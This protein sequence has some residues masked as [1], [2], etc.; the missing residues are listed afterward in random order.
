MYQLYKKLLVNFIAD[1]RI[2]CV[3]ADVTLQGRNDVELQNKWAGIVRENLSAIYALDSEDVEVENGTYITDAHSFNC[4]L[5]YIPVPRSRRPENR[6]CILCSLEQ[7]FSTNE[8]EIE[9]LE[10][11]REPNPMRS[12][13]ASVVWVGA[14]RIDSHVLFTDK[15]QLDKKTIL[16]GSL[17]D[18]KSFSNNHAVIAHLFGDSVNRSVEN[19]ELCDASFTMANMAGEI[20]FA[21]D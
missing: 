4:N 11:N 19:K 20:G 7:R 3:L 2:Q 18:I 10:E 16:I 14:G 13:T 1:G 5:Q 9:I 8:I 12:Y 15:A 17:S 21:F 6:N